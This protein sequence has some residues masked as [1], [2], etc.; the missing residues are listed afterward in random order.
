MQS[1]GYLKVKLIVREREGL[2]HLISFQKHE[3]S[4]QLLLS[5]DLEHKSESFMCKAQDCV[6]RA[7]SRKVHVDPVTLSNHLDR[8]L[9]TWSD[10]IA[11]VRQSAKPRAN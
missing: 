2:A 5:G 10:L 8:K 1:L 4:Q 11:R 9:E 7:R 3:Q 6:D